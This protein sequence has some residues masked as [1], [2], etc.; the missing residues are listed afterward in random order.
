MLP[1]AL[2][3]RGKRKREE[4]EGE[5]DS[6]IFAGR[7]ATST[8]PLLPASLPPP[9][10]QRALWPFCFLLVAVSLLPSLLSLHSS[11][12]A[13]HRPR[14]RDAPPVYAAAAMQNSLSLSL[15]THQDKPIG[16]GRRQ[17]GGQTHTHT[18]QQTNQLNCHDCGRSRF[19]RHRSCMLHT[20]EKRKIE[21]PK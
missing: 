19:T 14:P 5:E 1:T 12:P 13:F 3:R 18:H 8:S 16:A 4:G 11:P 9:C 17:S 6:R 20:L 10:V 21:A 7:R 2:L 15:P